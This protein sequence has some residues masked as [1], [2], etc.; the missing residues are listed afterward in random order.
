VEHAIILIL[1]PLNHRQKKAHGHLPETSCFTFHP[2]TNAGNLATMR[3]ASSRVSSLAAER[4]QRKVD[5][6][7]VLLR[8]DA[9]MQKPLMHAPEIWRFPENISRHLVPLCFPHNMIIR[10][11]GAPSLENDCLALAS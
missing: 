11:V 8:P 7:S 2:L 1:Q 3:R 4:Q 10:L 9:L 5:P 6:N